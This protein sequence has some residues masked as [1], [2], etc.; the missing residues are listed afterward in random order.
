ME[1]VDLSKIKTMADKKPSFFRGEQI[2]FIFVMLGLLIGITKKE[3]EGFT[4][5][6]F[7]VS[8]T[9]AIILSLIPIV[10]I[11]YIKIKKRKK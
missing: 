10:W 2:S 9:F 3:I 6:P 4:E 11:I 8:G 5:I 7:Q 1:L